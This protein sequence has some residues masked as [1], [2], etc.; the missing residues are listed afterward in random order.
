MAGIALKDVALLREQCFFD[1]AWIGAGSI[2]VTDPA[3][4]ETLASVPDLGVE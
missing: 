2:P 1:G 4:G 3:N